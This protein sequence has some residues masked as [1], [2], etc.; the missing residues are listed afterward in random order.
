MKKSKPGTVDGAAVVCG[1][2]W[3]DGGGAV[4][5]GAGRVD[6]GGAVLCGAGRV[7]WNA[8]HSLES[9]GS[10]ISLEAQRR[11]KKQLE[12]LR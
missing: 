11:C 1:A 6:G 3:V 12:R 5:C 2:G 7:A 8:E 4:V 9:A 10:D